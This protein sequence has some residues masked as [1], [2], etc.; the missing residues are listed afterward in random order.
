MDGLIGLVEYYK[1]NRV[2]H[3]NLLIAWKHFFALLP[4]KCSIQWKY[5]WRSSHH[6]YIGWPG[7]RYRCGRF[8]GGLSWNVLYH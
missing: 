2:K 5:W 4:P 3:Y 7:E 8:C 6:W 1:A